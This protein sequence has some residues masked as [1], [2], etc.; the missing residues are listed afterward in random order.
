MIEPRNAKE[1]FLRR[2]LEI[3]HNTS[4]PMTRQKGKKMLVGTVLSGDTIGAYLHYYGRRSVPHLHPDICPACK[5]GYPFRY[6]AY[7]AALVAKDD[8]HAIVEFTDASMAQ[9]DAAFCKYRTLRGLAFGLSRVGNAGNSRLF[10]RFEAGRRDK[11]DLPEAP[12]VTKILMNMW[13]VPELIQ[14]EFAAEM[15]VNR[16]MG[17]SSLNGHH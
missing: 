17:V 15:A 2:P 4:W 10:A 8:L 14:S 13:E 5:K 1:I 12:N 3:R 16:L 11:D 9:V 7:V 6:Y